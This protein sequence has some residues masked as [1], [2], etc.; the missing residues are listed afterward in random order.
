MARRVRVSTVSGYPVQ[1]PGIGPEQM[2]EVVQERWRE[3]LAVV[4]ADEPDLVVL[5]EHGDRGI[6]SQD[7]YQ[8]LPVEAVEEFTRFKGDKMVEFYGE[9]A[10]EHGTHI[11]YSGYRIDDDGLL[12]NSTQIIGA[13]GR[14]LGAYDKVHPTI[15]E[16]HQRKVVPGEGMKVVETPIGRI[17]PLIC[18]DLNF[19]E[20]LPELAALK[21]EIITFG[22]AYHGGFMQQYWAYTAQSWFV[23]SVHPPNTSQIISPVGH[24][25][26]T[27]VNYRFHVTTTINL[28]YKVLHIDENHLKFRRI[29]ERFGPGVE[30]LDPGRVGVVLLTSESDEFT[31]DDVMAEFQLA[32]LDDYFARSRDSNQNA[33]PVRF[34]AGSTQ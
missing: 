17:S 12:R 34:S 7:P 18:Y 9:I 23:G 14:V 16:H 15:A 1:V 24:E 13:D 27:T 5:P 28:D 25:V 26:A 29:K 31:V 33:Q 19:T 3:R 10:R 11:A 8:N 21:P 22:S 2:L 4:L 30:I 6:F 32:D 20:S